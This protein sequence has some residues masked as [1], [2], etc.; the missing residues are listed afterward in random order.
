MK[1]FNIFFKYLKYLFHSGTK[2]NVHPPFLFDLLT[3]VFDDKKIYPAY[4]NVENLKKQLIKN[5]Q[6]ISITDLGAGSSTNKN[7]ERTVSYIARTSSKN[8]KHGR[9]IYRL[10]NYFQP[11]TILELGTSLGLS[12][13]YMALGNPSSKV[14]TVEGC[15]NISGLAAENIKKLSIENINLKTG[16]FDELLPDILN[17]LNQLDFIFIDGNHQQEPTI[18]YFEQCLSKINNDSIF[19]F[20]DIHWSEGMERAWEYIK[21]HP[22]VTLS[23]DIFFMGIVFFKKELTKE[24]FTIRF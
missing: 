12:T 2:F 14:T 11:Q 7:P 13:A 15:P 17:S 5:K 21:Q 6:T 16:N 22:S 3:Q 10:V 8:K 4:H 23:I 9:L 20:D 19:I 1:S 24:H 18:K